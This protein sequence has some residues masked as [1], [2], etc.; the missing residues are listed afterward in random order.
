MSIAVGVFD[1]MDSGGQSPHV[2]YDSRLKLIEA[3]DV[4]GFYGYHVAE[5]HQTSLGIAP[6][7][8]VFLAAA[9]ARTTQ[10]KLGPG[11]AICLMQINQALGRSRF[12]DVELRPLEA[13]HPCDARSRP[14][15]IQSSS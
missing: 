11:Y 15:T 2:V 7:P 9:A 4:A 1:H 13:R 14:T 10:I 3:Y 8:G 12:L 6:S 5:H